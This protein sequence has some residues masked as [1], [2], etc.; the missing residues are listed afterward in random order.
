MTWVRAEARMPNAGY[1]DVRGTHWEIE[2]L[3]APT[4]GAVIAHAG[5]R[6]EPE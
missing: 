4:D 1:F 6:D 5:V 2:V 3:K